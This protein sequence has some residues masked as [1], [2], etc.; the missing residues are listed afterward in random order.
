MI[1]IAIA[2]AAF[3]PIAVSL[4]A[5]GASPPE[6]HHVTTQQRIKTIARWAAVVLSFLSVAFAVVSYDTRWDWWLHDDMVERVAERFDLSYSKDAGLP[7]QR[8]DPEWAPLLKLIQRYSPRRGELPEDRTPM[9]VARFQA[10]TAAQTAAGEWTAPT[11]PVAL[12]YRK[13]PDPGSG[14]LKPGQDCVRRR[15]DRRPT[16]LDPTRPSGLRLSLA[17]DRFRAVVHLRWC[18]PCARRYDAPAYVRT[19]QVREPITARRA[20]RR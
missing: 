13:W 4:Q 20:I 3:A 9:T 15:H 12:L 1:R 7:V 16:R 8:G 5:S 18:H 10:I 6:G 17:D 11:T 14:A 2:P 19:T